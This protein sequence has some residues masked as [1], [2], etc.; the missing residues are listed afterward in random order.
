MCLF[1]WLEENE[2]YFDK[3]FRLKDAQSC[4][5]QSHMFTSSL[6]SAWFHLHRLGEGLQTLD[7]H[8]RNGFSYCNAT[9]HFYTPCTLSDSSL[10]AV[11]IGRW[12]YWTVS[13]VVHSQY[14]ILVNILLQFWIVWI[15]VFIVQSLYCMFYFYLNVP[16]WVKRFFQVVMSFPY[17]PVWQKFI[18]EVCL[19]KAAKS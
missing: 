9:H 2:K 8:P 6:S 17:F 12:F 7:G 19:K 4:G 1:L 14:K 13:I 3:C 18:K 10:L 11:V 5:T 15:Y 16:C